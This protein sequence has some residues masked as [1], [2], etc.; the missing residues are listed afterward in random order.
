MSL[1]NKLQPHPS[2]PTHHPSISIAVCTWNRARMVEKTLESFTRLVVPEGVNWEV[3]VVNNN[4]PDD[5]ETVLERFA[6]RLPLRHFLETRQGIAHA[7][8]RAAREARNDVIL[9]TDDDVQ[10]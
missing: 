2:T 1:T 5:T 4:S 8:N 3:V 10:V 6:A 7:R 9:W